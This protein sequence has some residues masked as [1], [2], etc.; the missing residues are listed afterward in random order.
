MGQITSLFVKKVVGVVEDALDKDDLLKS[1]GIDPDSAAD[2]SQMVSDTNYYSF[3]EKIAIAEN[4]GT[5][6]PLRAGAAMR[7]DDYG[8]FGLAWKSA[9]HLDCYSY[10]CAFCLNR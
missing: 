4:N 1:L 7:C 5:T 2:P 6:L 8:A 3:L 9:T 10:F